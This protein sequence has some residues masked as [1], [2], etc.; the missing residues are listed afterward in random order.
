[1][2]FILRNIFS[3][4]LTCE[5]FSYTN[6]KDESMFLTWKPR[7]NTTCR[8]CP[9]WRRSSTTRRSL[10]TASSTS[11]SS[12]TWLHAP[13]WTTNSDATTPWARSRAAAL[14]CPSSSRTTSWSSPTS[15]TPRLFW[16]PHPTTTSSRRPAHRPPKA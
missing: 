2:T 12:P 7:T 3:M 8:R 5:S 4:D 9:H 13:L 16:A 6:A 1:V 14:R 11:G 15:V 10:V